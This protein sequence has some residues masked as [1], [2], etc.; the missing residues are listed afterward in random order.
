MREAEG[1]I[2]SRH[3]SW[4]KIHFKKTRA[5]VAGTNKAGGLTRQTGQVSSLTANIFKAATSRTKILNKTVSM[6]H[7]F[8][9]MSVVSDIYICCNAQGVKVI[10][11]SVTVKVN[12]HVS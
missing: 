10:I 3:I 2:C 8:Y 11:T 9:E 6:S 1:L 12:L 7:L 5:P 4:Q